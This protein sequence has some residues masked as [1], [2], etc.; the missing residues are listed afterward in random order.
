MI[1]EIGLILNELLLTIFKDMKMQ[2]SERSYL[3][4]I[5]KSNI[6]VRII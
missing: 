4:I 2:I 3:H 5:T 1:K 6:C